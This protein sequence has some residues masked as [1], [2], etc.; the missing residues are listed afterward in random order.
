MSAGPNVA[1]LSTVGLS[2]DEV[3]NP[4]VAQDSL[5]DFIHSKPKERRDK[6]SA[7]LG[8]DPLVRFK[9]AVDRARTRFQNDPPAAV[10]TRQSELWRIIAA[11]QQS[12][13]VR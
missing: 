2:D 13:S 11:M 3:F 12:P 5:Q 8:L 1:P 4:I 7:A 6:I 10:R 9:T